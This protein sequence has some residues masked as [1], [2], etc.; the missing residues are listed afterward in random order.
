MSGRV[1]KFKWHGH[2]SSAEQAGSDFWG[3]YPLAGN[4]VVIVVGDSVGRRLAGA[5]VSASVKSCCDQVIAEMGESLTPGELLSILNTSLFQ[6]TQS[7]LASCFVAILDPTRSQISYANAGHV[8]PYRV[9]KG[10]EGLALTVLQG[11]GPLLG[12]LMDPAF[13]VHKEQL[14]NADSVIF[15]TD[16]LLAQRDAR[17]DSYGYR[18]FHKLLKAQATTDPADITKAVLAGI[19]AHSA[20]DKLRDDQALLVVKWA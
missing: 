13:P 19:A 6:A 11:T 3:I 5:M 12:D 1:G 14:S 17:G 4:R 9:R 10:K 20:D 15:L 7:A 8:L 16:G 2:Y 18:R